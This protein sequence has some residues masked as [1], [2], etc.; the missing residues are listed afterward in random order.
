MEKEDESIIQKSIFLGIG[1]ANDE[2]EPKKITGELSKSNFIF[3]L[4]CVP[5]II[6]RNQ[7]VLKKKKKR[8]WL[9]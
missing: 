1:F 4:I 9:G 8:E 2:D 7:L 3:L 6:V 5:S